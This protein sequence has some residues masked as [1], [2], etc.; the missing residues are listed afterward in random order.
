M[1]CRANIR[2]DNEWHRSCDHR[3]WA[4]FVTTFVN[5]TTKMALADTFSFSAREYI[6]SVMTPEIDKKMTENAAKTMADVADQCNIP[7]PDCE[8]EL[9]GGD[10]DN[11]FDSSPVDGVGDPRKG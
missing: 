1:N 8:E 9:L 7:I 6:A 4:Q 2:E 11:A 10:V 3:E 5:T